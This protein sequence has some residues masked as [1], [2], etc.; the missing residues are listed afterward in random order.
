MS[1]AAATP[2][3]SGPGLIQVFFTQTDTSVSEETILKWLDEEH[4][5]ALMATGVAK[6]GWRHKAADSAYSK[7]HMLLYKVPDLSS[8]LSGKL[9]TV[10]RT[11]DLFPDG[12]PIDDFVTVESK[13]FT[14]VQLYE[15]TKQPE[16]AGNTIIMAAMEPSPGGEADL[17]AW[18]R[19]EH[20]EQMSKEPGY[21]RTARFSLLAQNRTDG[22]ESER[23]S[24]LA[25]HEFGEGHKI[26][27][28]V[29]PLDPMTEWTKR[30]MSNAKAI[31]AAIYNKQKVFGAAA[32]S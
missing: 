1:D 26:G 10:P 15:P 24:F 13:V 30:C 5:P 12:K 20:N 17:E 14:F 9:E 29:K 27:K 2:L 4:I 32:E 28:D 25:I 16:D 19:D 23:I 11:S 6:S 31:D 7:P 8:V 21:K 3:W 22:K 18:Y